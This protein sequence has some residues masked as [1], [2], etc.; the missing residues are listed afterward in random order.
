MRP[1]RAQAPSALSVGLA[2]ASVY[3]VWGS[4]YLAIR[5]GLQGYPPFLMFFF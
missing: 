5:V 3:L 1:D 4:T 2:L